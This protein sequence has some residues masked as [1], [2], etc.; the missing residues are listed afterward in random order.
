MMMFGQKFPIVLI[1]RPNYQE[2]LVDQNHFKL[3]L[4]LKLHSNGNKKKQI[5]VTTKLLQDFLNCWFDLTSQ[6]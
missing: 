2:N 1:H 4:K 5:L 3:T 6:V